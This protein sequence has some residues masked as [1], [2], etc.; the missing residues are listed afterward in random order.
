MTS[1]RQFQNLISILQFKAYSSFEVYF[2]RDYYFAMPKAPESKAQSSTKSK[3]T[4]TTAEAAGKK[5]AKDPKDSHLYT[6]DNPETTLHGTGFKDSE[7]AKHTI[8]LVN[9]RSLTYQFQ[10]INT[11]YVMLQS[12]SSSKLTDPSGTT[13]PK[14]IPTKPTACNPP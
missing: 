5:P 2:F 13:E 9:K 6:D 11:M 10:T 4:S 7:T 3:K 12:D 1:W 8:D 14:A